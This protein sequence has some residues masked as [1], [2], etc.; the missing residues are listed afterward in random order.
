MATLYSAIAPLSIFFGY[1]IWSTLL[2]PYQFYWLLLAALGPGVIASAGFGLSAVYFIL[3][4]IA[5]LHA[6]LAERDQMSRSQLLWAVGGLLMILIGALPL[7]IGMLLTLASINSDLGPDGWPTQIANVTMPIGGTAF[8][9]MIA[10]AILHYRLFDIDVI[11]RRTLTYTLLTLSLGT[12]YFAG[13]VAFQALFVRLT[14]EES[15]LAVVAITLAVAA[16]FQPLR[17]WVQAIIDRRFF[18]KKYNA[19]QVLEPIPFK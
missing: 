16:L 17:R 9:V 5:T 19:Q 14:G 11:I 12:I 3:A 7:F 15:T 8:Q 1:L 10:I 2:V 4:L 18:R 6:A 13:V